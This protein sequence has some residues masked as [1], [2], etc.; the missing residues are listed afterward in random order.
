MKK[1]YGRLGGTTCQLF[2][3]KPVY[4]YEISG[5]REQLRLSGMLDS[6]DNDDDDGAALEKSA[7]IVL[8]LWRFISNCE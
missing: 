4:D 8:S 7:V 2:K 6:V 5:R 3:Q 1:R